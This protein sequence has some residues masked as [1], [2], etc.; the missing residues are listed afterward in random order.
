MTTRRTTRRT[1]AA[2]AAS[3]ALAAGLSGC[4]GFTGGSDDAADG[5]LTFTTW[6]SE[7]EQDSFEKLVAQFESEHDGATV[8]LN[9][10]PYDQ[11]FSNIDAQ[12]STGDAPDV[13]RVDYGNL[14]VYSSQGQ[15]LDLTG[16]I[17]DEDSFQPAML[18][19][20]SYE[21]APYGVPHQ[22]DVSALLVNTELLAAAGVTDLPTSQAD[23]WTWDE[24]G[25]VATKLRA[26]LPA[27]QYPFGV[28][29]QQGGT[30]RWLSWLFQAGG[31]L[32]A[33][34]GTTSEIDSPEAAEAL[35]FTQSFFE[36]GWVAPSS[37]VKS[38]TYADTEFGEQTT[39]MAFVGSFL[40]PELA[41]TDFDWTAVPMPVDERGAT[42]L[43]G[44]ALVATADT[45]QGELATEFL[46]FM[47]SADAMTEFCAAT[48][49]LPTRTDIDASSIDFA[50]RPDVMPVFVDQATTIQ[51][52]DVKQLTSPYLAEITVAMQDQLEAAFTQGQSV[53]DTLSAL[54]EAVGQATD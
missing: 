52:S 39:A 36:Q 42:D 21:G 9:V 2:A 19:A 41:S 16:R 1:T 6:A 35:G 50:V 47:A 10:V 51:P 14:G 11:M 29:W 23:A 8:D 4:S 12:L 48:N 40:V 30:P 18:E 5:T 45:D 31:A 32:L 3:L 44:N 53:D 46:N 27:D 13:F 37:S 7:S 22:T 28:N 15:L 25:E 26:S 34:D 54:D 24:F 38:T 49:E 33:D 20:V 17:D 43:G